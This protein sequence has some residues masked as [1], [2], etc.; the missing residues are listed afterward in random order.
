[1]V[2]EWADFDPRLGLRHLGGWK[3]QDLPDILQ[4]VRLRAGHYF[5]ALTRAAQRVPVGLCLPTLALPPLAYQAGHQAGAWEWQLRECLG[6]FAARLAEQAGVRLVSPQRLDR[7]SPPAE[8]RDVQA[9]LLFG[10]PYRVPH[11]DAVADLLSRL[12]AHGAPKKGI[13]TDL[14]DTLWA[15]LLGEVGSDGVSWDMDHHSQLHGLYQQLLQ[16]LAAA[17]VLVAVASKNDPA[18]VDEALRRD[19]LILG[20]EQIFPVEVHRGPKSESVGR[21]LRA[22]NV[23]ADSVVFVDDS[24]MKVAEVQAVHP[25]VEGVVFPKGH[26]QAAYALL[27][28]LRD[29]FGKETVSE[30]DEIRLESLRRQATF[31]VSR[32][33]SEAGEVPED[34]LRQARAEMTFFT[35]KEP[36]ARAFEL[37]NKTNQF[38]LNG[39]R[40]TEAE[41]RRRLAD[42]EI[43]VWVVGYKD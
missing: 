33:A 3:P 1:M 7:R 21:I 19:D 34:F 15:G 11:A 5:E 42:P 38:N 39:R 31:T 25:G 41:W 12:I 43:F 36:D 37:L 27:E 2:L 9:E 14:D 24:P 6:A 20:R 13:I 32:D 4:T 29:L 16:A 18:R 28:R 35:D 8:R 10:F 30:E 22:W 17:S 40:F 26:Y 23:A